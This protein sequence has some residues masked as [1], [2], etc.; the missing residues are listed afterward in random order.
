MP[1]VRPRRLRS[2]HGPGPRTRAEANAR[3]SAED[4]P[5]GTVATRTTADRAPI[6][7][8]AVANRAGVLR[9]HLTEIALGLVGLHVL[10]ASLLSLRPGARVADHLVGLLAGLAVL[11]GAWAGIR[12]GRPGVAAACELCLV[13]PCAAGFGL[14]LADARARGLSGADVSGLL[15]IV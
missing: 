1:N 3:G 13:A 8:A 6:A 5:M 7:P 4:G 15:L 2:R 10:N 9:S 14:A 11:A 12:R